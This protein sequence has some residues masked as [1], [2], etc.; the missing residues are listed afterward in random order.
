MET[1]ARTDRLGAR[2]TGPVWRQV[3]AW[4]L[5][6]VFWLGMVSSLVA[7]WARAQ[8]L[9]TDA[10]VE[11][12]TPLA[13]D[14]AIQVAVADR[15]TSLLAEQIQRDDATRS[16]L[17]DVAGGASMAIVLDFVDRTVLDF[18]RSS[19]FQG[20]WVSANEIVHRRAIEALTGDNEGLIFLENG[21]LILDLNPIISEVQTRLNDAGLDVVNRIRIDPERATFVLFESDSVRRA[22]GAIELLD[23]LGIVLPIVTIVALAGCLLVAERP[24]PMVI[25]AGVGTAVTM[26]LALVVLSVVRDQYID[27]LNTGRDVDALAAAFDIVIRTL[28]ETVRVSAFAGLAVAGFAALASS[29]LIRQPRIVTLV[30]RYRTASIGVILAVACVVLAAVDRVSLE[31]AIGT[32]L[33]ALAAIVTV[34]WL[35]RLPVV[36]PLETDSP[37]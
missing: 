28:R 22:Q 15:V 14:P 27:A 23:I 19:E 8:V 35:A 10:W 9:D 21:Q 20:F 36:A 13:A 11:T 1:S 17:A 3:G 30:A 31:L 2:S 24:W 26:A 12:V 5:L 4:V 25:R 34:T 32:G 16:A 6:V 7:V 18:V 33:L 37:A 29:A